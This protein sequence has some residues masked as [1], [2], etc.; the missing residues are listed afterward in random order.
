MR[1][2]LAVL[3]IALLPLH[4]IVHAAMGA[5]APAAQIAAPAPPAAAA[6]GPCPMADL[7]GAA[8]AMCDLCCA[9]VVAAPVALAAATLP[10]ASPRIDVPGALPP[11]PNDRLYR[12]PR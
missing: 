10:T 5:A 3:L 12:P 11:A 7:D 8:C 2:W 1:R 9:V 6:D 4:G